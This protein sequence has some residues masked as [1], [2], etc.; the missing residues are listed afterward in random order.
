MANSRT[1]RVNRALREIA[2]AVGEGT[3]AKVEAILQGR[4]PG[5]EGT[6]FLYRMVPDEEWRVLEDWRFFNIQ[7]HEVRLEGVNDDLTVKLAEH[8]N[9]TLKEAQ[10]LRAEVQSLKNPSPVFHFATKNKWTLVVN[11][12][13]ETLTASIVNPYTDTNVTV[14]WAHPWEASH[15]GRRNFAERVMKFLNQQAM[16]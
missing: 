11:Q 3:R 9:R 12:R 10:A 15:Q 2:D 4:A 13:G 7:T 16:D 6:R 8:L 5:E 1:Y 14:P